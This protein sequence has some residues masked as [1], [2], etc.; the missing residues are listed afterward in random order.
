MRNISELDITL[1]RWVGQG[2]VKVALPGDFAACRRPAIGS[3]CQSGRRP[4]RS[5]L[6]SR[7][8]FAR[9][10]HLHILILGIDAAASIRDACRVQAVTMNSSRCR[11][12]RPWILR[13]NSNDA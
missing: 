6:G 2:H 13:S 5:D 10:G 1:P 9:V 4:F 8:A 12:Q 7:N 11:V 3:A